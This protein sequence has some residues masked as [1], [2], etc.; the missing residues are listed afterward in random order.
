MRNARCPH[1]RFSKI[2]RPIFPTYRTLL[3]HY[4]SRT[5]KVT[6]GDNNSNEYI[7]AVRAYIT[8]GCPEVRLRFRK[9]YERKTAPRSREPLGEVYV[10]WLVTTY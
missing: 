7:G 3:V 5:A 10:R 9:M 6:A 1:G 2:V 4:I 8:T